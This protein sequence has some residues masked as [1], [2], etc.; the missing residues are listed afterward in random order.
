MQGKPWLGLVLGLLTSLA[1]AGEVGVAARVNGAEISNFRLE[2]HFADYLKIQGRQVGAIRNPTVYKRLRR[3]ALQQLVDK[4]LLW[5]EAGRRHLAVSEQDLQAKVEEVK[6]A[7]ATSH[8][9]TRALGEAGFDEV[10]YREYLR[11]ELVA[12][13]MLDELSKV[14]APSETDVRS[15]YKSLR[16]QLDPTV[17]E[18]QGK[19]LARQYLTGQRMA[20]SR[21]LALE[22]LREQ[23]RI[24]VL[25]AL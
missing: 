18:A 22:K 11:H 21:E 20:Q 2:R 9:F 1:L 25:V 8:S 10:G 4:E 12:S 3:E 24:E 16:P 23:A 15:A 19:A 17:D 7:F 5:Q 13:R 6:V 14:S